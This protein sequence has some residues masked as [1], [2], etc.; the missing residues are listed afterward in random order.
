MKN[1]PRPAWSPRSPPPAPRGTPD[2][3]AMVRHRTVA[4]NGIRLRIAFLREAAPPTG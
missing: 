3:A 2:L 1:A 4:T